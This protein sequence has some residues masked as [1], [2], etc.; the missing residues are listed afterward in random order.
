MDITIEIVITD[1]TSCLGYSNYQIIR[2]TMLLVLYKHT[3]LLILQG[4]L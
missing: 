4:F 3:G 2:C 1:Q